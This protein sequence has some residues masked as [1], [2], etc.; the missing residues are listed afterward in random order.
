MVNQNDLY[1]Y[2]GMSALV[3]VVLAFILKV[4]SY[5]THILEGMTSSIT[6][7]DTISSTVTTNA[8]IISDQLLISKYRTNYEDTIINLEKS[9]GLAIV[10]EVINNA[11][12]I[13]SDATSIESLK[14]INNINSLKT[15]RESLNQSMLLVDKFA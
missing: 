3:L 11:E 15:F 12:I 4:F 5:Q 7:K 10:S 14:A 2:I 8:N 9:V 6:D 13:S 1:G